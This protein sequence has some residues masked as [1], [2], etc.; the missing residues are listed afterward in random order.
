MNYVLKVYYNKEGKQII[1]VE[2]EPA[3]VVLT[4]ELSGGVLSGL[5][6]LSK[7]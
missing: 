5:T 6:Q 1:K 4:H 7:C 3:F 2:A